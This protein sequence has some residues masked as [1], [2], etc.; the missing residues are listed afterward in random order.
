MLASVPVF[1]V[2]ELLEG[3]AHHDDA[4]VWR[5]DDER[6]IVA[7]TD[8]FT[9]V[10]DDPR[11]FGAIA[12]ANALSDVYAMGARPLFALNLVA[13]PV[14]TLPRTVLQEILAGGAAKAREAGVPIAGGHS[15]DDKEPKYGLVVI[16]EVHPQRLWRNH[17]ARPGDR[18]ILTKPL[19]VGVITTA[20]KR[21]RATPEQVAEVTDLMAT[22]NRA[23]AEAA[24]GFRDAVHAATDVTGFGLLGHLREMV[25]AT[26][27]VTCTVEAGRVPL[28][29]G[30][31]TLAE[32]GVVPGGSKRN[33]RWVEDVVATN[34]V[35]D[36]TMLLLADAQTSGGLLLAVDP[37][38]A[39]DLVAALE[40][41][42]APAA[43]AVGGFEAGAARLRV[44][45]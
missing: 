20:I 38:A 10:V 22:L 32:E 34:D 30:A 18:L 24:L 21:G 1:D 11:A 36:A 40:A 13:F 29:P 17:G 39:G 25:E 7:T 8:F 41:A 3:L 9:P 5:M 4:A 14:D 19:G 2:P 37:D 31:R 43:A 15:I 45:P 35:D 6:A 33:L 44:V 23:A 42:G 27:D 26:C 12:A 16:G 28:L